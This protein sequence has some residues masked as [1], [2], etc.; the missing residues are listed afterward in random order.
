MSDGV[1]GADSKGRMVR[2]PHPQHTQ[3]LGGA[4]NKERWGGCDAKYD[5]TYT[6]RHR[7]GLWGVGAVGAPVWRLRVRCSMALCPRGYS[8]ALARSSVVAA[9]LCGRRGAATG[10]RWATQGMACSGGCWVATRQCFAVHG[11]GPHC[12]DAEGRA[13]AW[14]LVR[15][16]APPTKETARS[17]R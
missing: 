9:I 10:H 12:R 4:W 11:V 14:V 13:G 6:R 7:M 8:A 16:G 5:H 17:A 15:G 3:H 2:Q 1:R